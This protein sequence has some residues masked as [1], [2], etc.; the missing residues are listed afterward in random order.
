MKSMTGYG[1]GSADGENFSVS[2]DL[3]TVNNRFLDVHLR[4]GGELAPLEPLIKRQ[5]SSRLSRGRVD[6]T[7]NLEK[8]SQ[9]AYEL[10]RPLIAGYVNALRE[11]QT[12]F[13]IA[14]EL[15]INLVAR[16]PGALQP[17]RDGLSDDVI[18]GLEKALAGALDE[19]EHM[20]TQEGEALRQEM[21]ERI[22]KIEALVPLIENAAAGLV[23]AYRARLQKRI[24]ELLARN[25]QLVE[26][27]HGRL[28]QE[29]AYLSDR[30]DVSE[31]MVRLRS[32]LIQFREALNS[33]SEAG[34][35]L[36]FLLQ[37]L[38]REANTTLSKSTD[39]SMKESALAI[40]A[41]VE[42]LREQ[43]QNVE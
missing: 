3:K 28:A 13:G 16:L 5:I 27:D 8:T 15:D 23:D 36:D 18:A 7:I 25:G 20:R 21:S 33:T 9:T 22:D 29:V 24:G 12:E 31:E 38:N 34:K 17:S 42:K 19:L 2:V 11:M 39:L 1:R 43:V 32:H 30:S 4:L 40:K 6:V 26:I 35:M 10:N 41:E 37:E 14:G